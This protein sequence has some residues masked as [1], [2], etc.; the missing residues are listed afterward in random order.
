L[1][2]EQAV[3][4]PHGHA[5]W[6]VIFN[7][8]SPNTNYRLWTNNAYGTA[9]NLMTA[10]SGFYNIGLFVGAIGTPQQSLELVGTVGNGGL[11]PGYFS[12]ANPF[13]LPAPYAAGT[14]INFQIRAWSVA[15]GANWNTALAAS[16]V[17][18]LNIALGVSAIGTVTPGSTPPA[19]LFGTTP[20]LLTSGH[21]MAPI[22]EPST[23]ALGLLGLG[24]L[25]VFR[26][27]KQD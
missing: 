4:L 2:Y 13:Q 25:L 3:A 16:A 1:G 26:R 6:F 24:T 21:L 12:G 5:S 22:P 17:D 8:F 14:P 20:G 9:S 19:P 23:I 27:R 15:G 10:A 11:L 18:P 7:N